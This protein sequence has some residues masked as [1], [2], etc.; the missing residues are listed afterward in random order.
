MEIIYLANVRIPTEKAHGIQI[1]KMCQ[2]FCNLGHQVELVAAKRI[3]RNFKKIDVFDYYKI[4]RRFPIVRL[5]L[6]DLV[7][8]PLPLRGF[9]VFIQNTSFALSSFFYLLLRK[10]D[11]IYS[12]DEFSLFFLS[13]FKKNLV[14][15]LHTFPGSKIFL[16]KRVF[17]KVRKIVVINNRL[18]DLVV[19]LGIKPDKV[20]IAHDGVDLDQFDIEESKEQARRKLD[21]PLD[22]KLVIY[23]GQLFEW[24]GVYVLAQASRLLG[25]DCRVIL[26]GGMEKDVKNLEE[27]VQEKDLD[28]VIVLGHQEPN[29]IPLY[30]KAA[31]LLVLPNSAKE[32]ISKHWTSP[33]KMFEYMAS[34]RPIVASDLPSLREVLNEKNAIL[35]KPD[36]NKR[37]AQ[38]IKSILKKPQAYAKISAQTYQDV[39][40]YTWIERSKRI[41]NFIE[42]M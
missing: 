28:K 32:E 18:K 8:L 31:D 13:F 12:R 36:D 23:T 9:W 3:N 35:I 1:M 38:A 15:E 2:A 34:K 16:Y 7:G 20:L 6:L 42:R 24:K 39:Q 21:L 14:L 27:F 40:G 30:L 4:S 11:L 19:G 17:K 37:L 41:L 33:M 26:V 29:L 25:D 22:K 5:F 10:T